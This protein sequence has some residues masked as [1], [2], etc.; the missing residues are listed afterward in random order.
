MQ[1]ESEVGFVGLTWACDIF[2]QVTALALILYVPPSQGTESCAY[3]ID[4]AFCSLSGESWEDNDTHVNGRV[5]TW[6]S[7]D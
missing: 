1:S 2:I 4:P 5:W 7:E 6:Q 3:D